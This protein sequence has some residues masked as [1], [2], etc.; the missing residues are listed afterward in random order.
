MDPGHELHTTFDAD[1]TFVFSKVTVGAVGA[2]DTE[3]RQTETVKGTYELAGDVL[4]AE[5]TYSIALVRTSDGETVG[6]E[7]LASDPEQLPVW[8]EAAPTTVACN[9]DTLVLTTTGVHGVA[10]DTEDWKYLRG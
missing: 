2:D 7:A 10:D 8:L 6:A 5:G 9:N 4:T 3:Y 1:G